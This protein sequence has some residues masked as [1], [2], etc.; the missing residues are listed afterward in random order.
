MTG[1]LVVVMARISPVQT[2]FLQTAAVYLLTLSTLVLL[3]YVLAYWTW[4]WRAPKPLPAAAAATVPQTRTVSAAGLFGEAAETGAPA[5]QVAGA[6]R[7]LG[8]VAASGKRQGHAI[9]QLED[10]R[11]V[12]VPEGGDLSPGFRLIQV[13]PEQ[14]V[15]MRNG[16]RETLALTRRGREK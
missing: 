2:R 15:V 10:R 16:V 12:S 1:S 13:G 11:V 8:V 3:G 14:V 6:I 5:A 7:L 4:V 9:F